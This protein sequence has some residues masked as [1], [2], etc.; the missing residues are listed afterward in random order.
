M[1]ENPLVDSVSSGQIIAIISP[2]RNA[3]GLA[4]PGS[5]LKTRVEAI[6]IVGMKV[7]ALTWISIPPLALQKC[8]P[9]PLIGSTAISNKRQVRRITSPRSAGWLALRIMIHSNLPD[10]PLSSMVPQCCQ[11]ITS[12]FRPRPG[13]VRTLRT[14]TDRILARVTLVIR[15]SHQSQRYL[16]MA[17]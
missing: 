5:Y 15:I 13:L 7:G 3:V 12:A 16:S 10:S 11:T 1:G 4:G 6:S 14:T 9:F 17:H 2:I 8:P